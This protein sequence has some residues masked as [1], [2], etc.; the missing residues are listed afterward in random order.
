MGISQ[1]VGR[2][3]PSEAKP[4]RTWA[5]GF[6]LDRELRKRDRALFDLAIDSKLRGCDLLE[7]K[8]GMPMAALAIRTHSMAACRIFGSNLRR[9]SNDG[10]AMGLIDRFRGAPRTTLAPSDA[11]GPA[12]ADWWISPKDLNFGK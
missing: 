3:E 9:R 12:R 2:L 4:W 8:I 6:F 5:I 11:N 1:L 7:I 10:T